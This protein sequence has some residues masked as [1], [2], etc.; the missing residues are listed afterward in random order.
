MTGHRKNAP[1]TLEKPR[2]TASRATRASAPVY[3][4][5]CPR[6]GQVRPGHKASPICTTCHQAV[7]KQCQTEQ[8][9]AYL[10]NYLSSRADDLSRHTRMLRDKA[11]RLGL[12]WTTP[13][14][15]LVFTQRLAQ[16][17]APYAA[18]NAA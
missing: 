17:L 10:V 14:M 12:D 16:A 8:E 5:K 1:T 18:A 3:T 9:L 15:P 2:Q 7:V 4:L 6:C 11:V 13:R